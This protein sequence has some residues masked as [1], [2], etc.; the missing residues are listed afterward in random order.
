MTIAVDE[1][2]LI[3][4]PTGVWVAY[5]IT[6]FILLANIVLCFLKVRPQNAFEPKMTPT[7]WSNAK[8][9]LKQKFVFDLIGTLGSL[10]AQLRGNLKWAVRFRLFNVVRWLDFMRLVKFALSNTKL[11]EKMKY[12]Y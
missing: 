4:P 9:Y 6:I 7:L 1:F 3:D 11:T 8:L 12:R 2:Y 10:I 5:Y